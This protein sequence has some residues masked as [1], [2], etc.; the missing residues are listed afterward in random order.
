MILPTSLP[1]L[2]YLLFVAPAKLVTKTITRRAMRLLPRTTAV[3]T[4]R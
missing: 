2:R 1:S 3:R 4:D